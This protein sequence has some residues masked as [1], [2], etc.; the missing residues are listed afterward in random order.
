MS[1]AGNVAN[2]GAQTA[3]LEC[4]GADHAI[5]VLDGPELHSQSACVLFFIPR[6]ANHYAALHKATRAVNNDYSDKTY[7]NLHNPT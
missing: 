5:Y 6:T 3:A 1:L 7:R 4:G 2:S